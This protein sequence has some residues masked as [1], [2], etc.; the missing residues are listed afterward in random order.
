MRPPVSMCKI[1]AVF[2]LGMSYSNAGE[3]ASNCVGGACRVERSRTVVSSVVRAP[4]AM[5]E[6]IVSAPT[7]GRQVVRSKTITTDKSD[8]CNGGSCDVR[9]DVRYRNRRIIV[10]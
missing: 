9:S 10:R 6:S 7:V 2:V 4:V 1:L 8:Y 3:F 5:V